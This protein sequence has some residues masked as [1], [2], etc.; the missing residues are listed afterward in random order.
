[1]PPSRDGESGND[2]PREDENLGFVYVVVPSFHSRPLSPLFAHFHFALP[3]AT[4][5]VTIQTHADEIRQFPII[6]SGFVRDLPKLPLGQPDLHAFGLFAVVR[7]RK[8]P[9]LR[10]PKAR[11]KR[12]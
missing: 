6:Q 1:M 5:Q 9:R 4:V 10:G 12:N 8:R 2:D 3:L 11:Q 7:H